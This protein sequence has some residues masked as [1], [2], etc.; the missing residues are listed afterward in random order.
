MR[1][2]AAEVFK[3][4]TIIWNAKGLDFAKDSGAGEGEEVVRVRTVWLRYLEAFEGRR[5]VL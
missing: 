2:S 1:R 5:E 4:A 3:V